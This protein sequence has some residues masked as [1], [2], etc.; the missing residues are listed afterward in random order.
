MADAKK[1]SIAAN[2]IHLLNLK[3]PERTGKRLKL[4]FQR[5]SA[6]VHVM[7]SNKSVDVSLSLLD[8]SETGVGFFS[9]Q[10]LLKGSTIEL[11]L[12]EPK[13]LRLIGL[14]AWSVPVK[15]GIHKGKFAYRSGMQFQ[16]ENEIQ[17]GSLI[18]F[19]QKIAIE[20]AERFKAQLASQ[21]EAL[22]RGTTQNPLPAELNPDNDFAP[23]PDAAGAPVATAPPAVVAAAPV[24]E[25]TTA[26]TPASPA[27]PADAAAPVVTASDTPPAPAPTAEVPAAVA[28]APEP[29]D[30]M[31]TIGAGQVTASPADMP[32]VAATD[33]KKDSGDSG[34]Q[35]A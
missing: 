1:S 16:F 35:A 33:E 30:E 4:S 21:A 8:I 14:V 19:I 20:P 34:S 29:T 17:R 2:T 9:D 23:P 25:P 31:P 10:L 15:S 12:S 7:K 11:L 6:K 27:A 26:E 18:D 13:V 24:A 5:T 22:A 32:A 28:A 3:T